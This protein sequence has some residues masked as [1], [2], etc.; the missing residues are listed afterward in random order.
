MNYEEK[1]V[2]RALDRRKHILSEYWE[3]VETVAINGTFKE[4]SEQ[5]LIFSIWSSFSAASFRKG[6]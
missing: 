4:G 5:N 1:I 3:H 2:I 6:R